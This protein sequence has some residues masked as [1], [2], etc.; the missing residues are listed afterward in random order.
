MEPGGVWVAGSADAQFVVSPDRGAPIRL[1]IRNIP[2]D[3][4][5]TLES[6]PW[7]ETLML[8]S[9]EERLVEV[10]SDT[11]RLGT[12]LRITASS[13]ARPVD[14]DPNSDDDRLLGCW[15]ETR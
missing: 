3:N 13:G 12:F 7:Q 14:F 11:S 6:G 15:I 1:F 10:P 8:R 5:V 2:I 9:R 4:K